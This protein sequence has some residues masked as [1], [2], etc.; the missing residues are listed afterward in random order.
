MPSPIATAEQAT[1][2]CPSCAGTHRMFWTAETVRT[3]PDGSTATSVRATRYG[4]CP[5]CATTPAPKPAAVKP[6]SA[7]HDPWAPRQTGV[8]K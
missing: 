1:A 5:D 2:P 3:L 7:G 4:K 8:R 6:G